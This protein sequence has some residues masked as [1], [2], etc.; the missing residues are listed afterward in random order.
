MHSSQKVTKKTNGEKLC[1]R[2]HIKLETLVYESEH[3]D[4][5][6][7]CGGVWLDD[8]ELGKLTVSRLESFKATDHQD[9]AADESTTKVSP[10]IDLFVSLNCASCRMPMTRF[11]YGYNSGVVIDKCVHGHGIWLDAQ[12]LDRIQIFIERWEGASSVVKQKYAGVLAAARKTAESS[13]DT[14]VET[15]KKRGIQN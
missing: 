11:N 9:I 12:E 14:A 1:P 3:I 13:F 8:N 10:E 7:K 4:C 15:G 6:R 2:H 5:C